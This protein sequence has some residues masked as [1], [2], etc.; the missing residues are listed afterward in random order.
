MAEHLTGLRAILSTPQV[1]LFFQRSIGN[2]RAIRTFIQNF[3]A[4]RAG[5]RV[6]DVGCGPG[7]VVEMLP[8]VT[9]VGLDLNA[10]Y[11][12]YARKHYHHRGIFLAEDVN[13]L[14]NHESVTPPFDLILLSQVAHHLS[15]DEFTKLLKVLQQLL[16]PSGRICAYDPCYWDGQPWYDRILADNDRGMYVRKPEGYAA[17]AEEIFPHVSWEVHRGLLRVPGSA[18]FLTMSMV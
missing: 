10:S 18:C 15:D 8:A 3:V 17:L 9:Y 2:R 16:A 13:N 1:Y 4:P 14:K 7:D 5:E 6:L 12:D 11:I